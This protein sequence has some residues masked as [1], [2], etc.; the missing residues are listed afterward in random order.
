MI[1]EDCFCVDITVTR[2]SDTIMCCTYPPCFFLSKHAC[3]TLL[4]TPWLQSQAMPAAHLL[5][6]GS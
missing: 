6:R 4:V 3:C 1:K 2:M 5:T